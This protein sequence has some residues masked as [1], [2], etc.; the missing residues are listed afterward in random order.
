MLGSMAP[1][2][3]SSN[4]SNGPPAVPTSFIYVAKRFLFQQQLNNHMIAIGNNPTREDQFRLQGV[5]WIND[6]RKVLSLYAFLSIDH[7]LVLIFQQ[8]RQHLHRSNYTLP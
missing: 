4:G 6:V 8:P 5:Q 3:P 2:Q 1:A 7:S